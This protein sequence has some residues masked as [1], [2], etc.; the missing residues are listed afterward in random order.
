MHVHKLFGYCGSG[1]MEFS[2][3]A[4]S[5][6]RSYSLFSGILFVPIL[7][8]T[9][10]IVQNEKVGWDRLMD[11][12]KGSTEPEQVHLS[13]DGRSASSVFTCD[14]HLNRSAVIF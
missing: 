11:I 6:G 8:T 5:T 1:K 14:E 4:L 3:L 12:D 7:F 13:W 10:V 2:W 9:A